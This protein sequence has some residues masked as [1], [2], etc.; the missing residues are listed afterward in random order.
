MNTSGGDRFSPSQLKL[1][2]TQFFGFTPQTCMIR[3]NNAFLDCVY[4]ILPIVEK[5]CVRQLSK[6]QMDGTEELLRSR[7]RECSLKL[8]QFLEERFKQL[9]KRMEGLLVSHCFSVPPNVLLPEDQSHKNYPQDMQ[10][11]Q[12]LESSLAALQR[13]FEAE[14]CARRALLAEL[15]EQREVQKQLDEILTWVGELQEAWVKE[16]NGSFHESFRLVMESV[17]KLQEAV[18]EVLVQQSSSMN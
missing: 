17:K 11:V 12:K 13:A 10:E 9:S 6:G 16:G 18:R 3:I 15:E 2:E 4:E 7:A 5:V 8:Q 1:Y 14:V